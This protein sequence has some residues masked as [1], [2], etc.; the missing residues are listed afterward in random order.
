[1]RIVICPDSF[2][3]SLTALEVAEAMATGFRRVWPHADYDLSPL[4]DGGEGTVQ[5]MLDATEGHWSSAE[6]T[7]PLGT[8]VQARFGLLGKTGQTGSEVDSRAVIEMAEASGLHLVPSAQRDP[9]VTT[10]RGTGEL[11]LA[12]LDQGATHLILGLG[13]SATNDGG[14]GMLQALGAE[15]LDARGQPIGPGGGSLGDLARIDLAGLDARL[16]N[17]TIEVACD[18][19][20]PLLGEQGASAVF[21]PQKGADAAMVQQ[22]DGWLG[23]YGR[24][25]ETTTGRSVLNVPG[26][27]AA[28]GM[29]AAL[30][31]ALE[32][33]LKPGIDL[34]M[35]A[36]GL[37]ERLPG[38]DLVVTGE[39]RLDS[40]TLQGK[41][42]AGA[43][44]LAGEA[45]IP[46]IGLA[47]GLADDAGV[48]T[49]HGFSAVLG[50]VQRPTDLDT[51]LTRAPEWLAR[52]AEQAAR[53]MVLGGKL[54][55]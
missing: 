10:S 48:L 46:V 40:Q 35:R 4:A 36:V 51:A 6:V 23:Q 54:Q 52:A 24:L 14:A 1:M 17:C 29:G 37:A 13:G 18:V 30:V 39:G 42:P 21:G 16:A 8:P 41:T 26:A 11:M 15:L 5:A 19:T 20:N 33:E 44:R 47:G 43:A 53:L 7:G 32:A 9:R 2:K 3:E 25:L 12:A 50:A 31:G 34:V 55:H 38:A 27:G 28:G 22:L 49:E 45:G